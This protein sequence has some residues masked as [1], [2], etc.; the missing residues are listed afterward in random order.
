MVSLKSLK[1]ESIGT[2]SQEK[3]LEDAFSVIV[4]SSRTFVRSSI[5]HSIP[6]APVLI[7]LIMVSSSLGRQGRQIGAEQ[8]RYLVINQR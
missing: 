1:C 4:K 7:L 6:A 8:P 3:A 5:R 2:F